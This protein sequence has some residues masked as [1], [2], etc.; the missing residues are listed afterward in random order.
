MDT[1]DGRAS[2]AFTINQYFMRCHFS[3]NLLKFSNAEEKIKPKQIQNM[4]PHWKRRKN[5]ISM[6]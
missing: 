2:R 3:P 5:R 6:N 4:R 1:V